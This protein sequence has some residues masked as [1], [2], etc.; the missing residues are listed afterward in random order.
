MTD[1]QTLLDLTDTMA[2]PDHLKRAHSALDEIEAGE[3]EIEA[4]DDG[5][6]EVKGKY[7]V[8]LDAKTCEC[9]D[10]EYRV[11]F[12][13]HLMAT[14]LQVFWGNVERVET[15]ESG[16][17]PR[18]DVL[19]VE[20]DNV[21]RTLRGM[22]HWVCWKQQLHEN[23]DGSK[24]WTKVPVDAQT[25][26]FASS[27]D[28]DTWTSYENAAAYAKRS[29]IAAC[30]IGFVV[31]DEDA[32][33]GID[34]DDCR[35]PE[36]GDIDP[37]VVKFLRESDTYAEVSPSGTGLRIFVLGDVPDDTANEADL[38]GEA[39]IEMYWT[40]RYLTVTGQHVDYTNDDLTWDDRTISEFVARVNEE[41]TDLSE[42]GA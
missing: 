9:K 13:K 10:Y 24:R 23:K 31:G 30:G 2:D 4:N 6:F 17:P 35:D 18:P 42:F 21:P 12:C 3:M 8:D 25:G 28:P 15:D 34:I 14:E 26:N 39:H 16:N 29:D 33:I 7:T 40:G 32:V 38:P 41:K 11:D 36:T 5:T 37:V 20:Y 27:T 19:P 1:Q 22:N